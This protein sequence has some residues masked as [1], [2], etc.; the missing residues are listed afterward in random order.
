MLENFPSEFSDYYSG[1]IIT[2]LSG[3]NRSGVLLPK[4]TLKGYSFNQQIISSMPTE[5]PTYTRLPTAHMLSVMHSRRDIGVP[6]SRK[7]GEILVVLRKA[8]WPALLFASCDQAVRVPKA[9]LPSLLDSFQVTVPTVPPLSEGSSYRD[10]GEAGL[11]QA[12]GPT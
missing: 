7:P 5:C 12:S 9:I 6:I 3:I 10:P 2:L 4:D 8:H 11:L 1:V